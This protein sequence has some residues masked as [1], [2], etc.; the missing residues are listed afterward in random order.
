MVS[1]TRLPLITI[2]AAMVV[3]SIIYNISFSCTYN[4]VRQ[5]LL[6]EQWQFGVV[7]TSLRAQRGQ[8]KQKNAAV[9]KS[10]DERESWNEIEQVLKHEVNQSKSDD[11][12]LRQDTTIIVTTNWIPGLPSTRMIDS[13]INSLHYLHGLSSDTPL[14][15]AA[16]GA[17]EGGARY[18]S[19]RNVDMRAYVWALKNKYNNSHTTVLSSSKK[20]MLVGNMKRALRRVETEFILVLQHDL[21]FVNEVNHTALVETM[22]THPEVRLVRFPTDRVLIRKRDIGVCNEDE[23]EFHANGIDLSK[24]HTWSDRNHLTRKSYYE[25]MFK[26]PGWEGIRYMELHMSKFARED[27][28]HWGTHLYGHRGANPTIFHLDGRRDGEHTTDTRN[29]RGNLTGLGVL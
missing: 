13:V 29:F 21:P 25:E 4:L 7:N 5:F 28:S 10:R 14:I 12:Q 26:L 24:T 17:Y 22:H 18:E 8:P 1:N 6:Q 20:R 16:D 27:C 23:I 19:V 3:S 15:I 9:L 11:R 2:W